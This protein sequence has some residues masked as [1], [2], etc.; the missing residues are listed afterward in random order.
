[1]YILG[2]A[3][4]ASS[5][6]MWAD[7]IEILRASDSIGESLDL[8]CP[9]HKDTEIRVNEPEVSWVSPLYRIVSAYSVLPPYRTSYSSRPKGV[10]NYNATS[11]NP[12]S[13]LS[14]WD[15]SLLG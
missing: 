8:C 12:S 15:N 5:V 11:K 7:V 9:R 14:I 4:T 13:M 6:K 2:N 1:M 3:D 10:A